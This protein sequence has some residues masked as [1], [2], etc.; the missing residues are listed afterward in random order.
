M[1]ASIALEAPRVI[2]IVEDQ[3]LLAVALK[4]ELELSGYRVLQIAARH[5]EAIDLAANDRPDLALVNITLADGDDGVALA[6]DL[7]AIGIPVLFI[8]G[9]PARA[10]AARAV[11]IGSLPK[12][13]SPDELV[14][15][16]DYL[17]QRGKPEAVSPSPPR[18]ELFYP[19]AP[20]ADA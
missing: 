15:A 11:A 1:T 20:P 16:V 18:L 6:W 7:K 4:D 19:T 5:S 13:Y 14:A 10:T 9:Q 8:S 3:F 2:L 17:F 12:P